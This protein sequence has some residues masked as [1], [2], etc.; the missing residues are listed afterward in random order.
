MKVAFLLGRRLIEKMVGGTRINYKSITKHF[1][2]CSF[3]FNL[4]LGF[5]ND[6]EYA[7]HKGGAKSS[8]TLAAS[9]GMPKWA[10]SRLVKFPR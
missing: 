7:R 4:S 5:T 10:N 3:R 1:D 2:H 9:I 8:S 6:A